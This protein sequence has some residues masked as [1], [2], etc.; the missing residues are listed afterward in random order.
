MLISASEATDITRSNFYI[1]IDEALKVINESIESTAKQGKSNCIV[2][3]RNIE[4]IVIDR[5]EIELETSKFRVKVN[6]MEPFAMC[7]FNISWEYLVSETTTKGL[8]SE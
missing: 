2:T 7:K 1:P 6:I 4:K 3:L 5:L 8:K